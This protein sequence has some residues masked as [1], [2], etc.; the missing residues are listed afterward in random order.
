MVVGEDPWLSLSCRWVE[1]EGLVFGEIVAPV[2]QCTLDHHQLGHPITGRYPMS[3]QHSPT[4][5]NRESLPHT[6]AT[7]TL[8]QLG[9]LIDNLLSAPIIQPDPLHPSLHL[10]HAFKTSFDLK[11]VSL[12]PN[13]RDSF[14]TFGPSRP[15]RIAQWLET[16]LAS[17]TSSDH[18]NDLARLE[19]LTGL[20]QGIKGAERELGRFQ[21]AKQIE[22]EV[23]VLL[24][25]EFLKISRDL[26]K[27]KGRER[28][29]DG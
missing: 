6:L 20:L 21:V 2:V 22:I 16:L 8:D 13:Q 12:D 26:N 5:V 10:N 1:V 3:N 25:Q 15:G 9:P 17:L 28:R 7:L 14:F 4:T 24:D 18:A 23:L 29:P 11:L 19:M 27:G